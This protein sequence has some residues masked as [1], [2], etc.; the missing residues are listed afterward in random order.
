MTGQDAV[1]VASSFNDKI[2]IDGVIVT[3]LDGDTRGLSLIHIQMCIRDRINGVHSANNYDMLQNIARDEWGFE[4]LVMTD[5]YTS[6]DTTAVSYTH[7][8]ERNRWYWSR[9]RID[10]NCRSMSGS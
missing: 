7:L 3:K 1:N 4:G 2:G 6:Q 8:S 5:W 9:N 10:D